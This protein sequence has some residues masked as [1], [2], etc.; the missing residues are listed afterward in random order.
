M[1]DKDTSV[2][3]KNLIGVFDMERTTADKITRQFL[4]NAE[5]KGD[6]VQ[7]TGGQIPRSFVVTEKDGRQKVRLNIVSSGTIGEA[8]I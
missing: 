1:I 8:R 7:D 2:L 6:M 5:S 3:A 4:D